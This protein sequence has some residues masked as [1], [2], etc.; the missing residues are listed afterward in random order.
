VHPILAAPQRLAL[1]LLAW[2]PVAAFLVANLGRDLS[3]SVA[4]LLFIPL[5]LVY[6]FVCLSAWYT[7]RIFPLESPRLGGLFAVTQIA[8]G[9]MAG[10]IWVLLGEI[11][12]GVLASLGTTEIIGLF[13]AQRPLLFLIGTL[14]FWLAVA[15]HAAVFAMERSRAAERR[16]ADEHLFA[17]E[18]ELRALRA[19]V[20]PHFLFNSLNSISALTSTDA[21][22]ARRMCLL[23]ADFL[24]DTLRSASGGRIPLGEELTL[25][26]R[27]LAIEQVRLGSRLQVT[28][29]SDADAEA[30]PVPPL[31][32]QPLV[33]NA[34]VHGVDH[35][36]DRA[37]VSIAARLE[38]PMLAIS[39]VN[40]CDPD[41]PVREGGG[42][43]LDLVRRRL[44]AEFGD[45]A[46]LQ[47]RD[48]GDTFSAELRIPR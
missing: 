1:Y 20:D 41:R 22:A 33:E 7:S 35:L 4:A 46:R 47:V 17:R 15:A 12:S 13:V 10:S 14:L 25:V 9:A 24:R 38:G 32:L 42:L 2:M 39:V 18:A 34:I 16:A 21:A 40:G 11:W 30:C 37:Q 43:G 44:Q 19:Q 31:I 28:R 26:E 36:I 45:R 48:L 6:A 27:Y 5:T 8:A 29:M 23:L 3:W